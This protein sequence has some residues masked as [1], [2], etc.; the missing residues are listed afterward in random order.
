M[1]Y[2]DGPLEIKTLEGDQPVGDNETTDCSVASSARSA[3]FIERLACIWR[4]SREPTIANQ[5]ASMAPFNIPVDVDEVSQER[6]FNTYKR[7][8]TRS[9]SL[10]DFVNR[11]GGYDQALVLLLRAMS[12]NGTE[13]MDCFCTPTFPLRSRFHLLASGR[14]VAK[15][16][17]LTRVDGSTW[18][19]GSLPDV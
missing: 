9:Y 6:C 8:F 17:I 15:E 10:H 13:V 2:Y 14:T 5:I 18:Y 7:V 16:D 4:S 3:A 19:F 11:C 12:D 1:F